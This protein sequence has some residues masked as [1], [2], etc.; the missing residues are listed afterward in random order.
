[1][2]SKWK[3]TSAEKIF[4]PQTI[5]GLT[6]GHPEAL[7]YGN[8]TELL[9]CEEHPQFVAQKEDNTDGRS[10]FMHVGEYP[11]NDTYTFKWMGGGTFSLFKRYHGQV[12]SNR[13][14]DFKGFNA[15]ERCFV[16]AIKTVL[17][18]DAGN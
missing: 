12:F 17:S 18:S 13:V 16:H 8:D 14:T 15:L 2:G 4:L 6:V 5:Q 1:M 9:V 10:F 3:C 7:P 11:N